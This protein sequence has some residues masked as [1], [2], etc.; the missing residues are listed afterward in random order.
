MNPIL[1]IEGVVMSGEGNGRTLGYP[2]IN[3]SGKYPLSYGV[4]VSEVLALGKR[5]RGAL[6]YGPRTSVGH[7][8]VVLE[9]HLLDFKGDLTGETVQVEVYT[10]IRDTKTFESVDALKVQ[11][12]KDIELVKKAK[13]KKL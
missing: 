2:T 1:T 9:V 10:K 7:D 6:H 12:A 13:L 11:I 3:I 4:Y 8:D 5:Y